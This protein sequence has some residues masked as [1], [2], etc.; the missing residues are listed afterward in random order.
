[1][2]DDKKDAAETSEEESAPK[3]K[4][5]LIAIVALVVILGAGGV[6][7]WLLMTP[8]DAGMETADGESQTEVIEPLAP[9]EYLS[10]EPAFVVS[11]SDR[12][13]QRF[14]QANIALMTRDSSILIAVENHM[15]LIRHNLTNILTSQSLAAIQSPEGIRRLQQ[16]AT[17]ELKRI[18]N[19]EVGKDSIDEVLFTSFVMQ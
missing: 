1:M 6:G 4:M 10:L 17:L 13:R 7:Y 11:F 3:S 8:A 2:A 9:T 16:E 18:L 19:E 12:G 5:K 15:P 14:V